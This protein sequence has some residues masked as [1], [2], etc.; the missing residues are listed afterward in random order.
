[1][2]D[3]RSEELDRLTE[4]LERYL[5]ELR[6][7]RPLRVLGSGFRSTALETGSGWVVRFGRTPDAAED[8]EKEWRIAGFLGRHLPGLV[9]APRHHVRPCAAFPFGAIAYPKLPGETPRW[10]E[11][12]GP[13]FAADLGVFMARLHSMPTAEA[14]AAGV[15]AVDSSRRLLGARD[16]VMPTLSDRLPADELRLVEAWWDALRAEARMRQGRE[17]VCHH[18][19][20]HDNLLRSESGRLSG[21]LDLAHVEI[22]DPAHDFAA[23]RYFGQA[24]FNQLL[25]AY[26]SHGGRFDADDE[27]RANRFFEGREFGGL[28]WAVEHQDDGEI[29][30]ALEKIRN[31]PILRRL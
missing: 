3:E 20:W 23:P 6:P 18:D 2:T 12:P 22:T 7:L 19:L 4:A 29:E 9:P 30:S 11:D 16:V 21:V 10:R 15:P 13:L 24:F 1:V 5:P 8:Y 25:H 31:G 28:A 17:A 27:Y 14:R 26:L